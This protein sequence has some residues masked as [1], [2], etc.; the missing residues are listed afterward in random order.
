MKTKLLILL[1]LLGFAAAGFAETKPVKALSEKE[2]AAFLSKRTSGSMLGSFDS[3]CSLLYAMSDVKIHTNSKEINTTQLQTVA[4]ADFYKPTWRELFDM[5]AIQTR[6]EWKYDPAQDSWGFTKPEKPKTYYSLEM[7]K[8]WDQSDRGLYVGYHPAI[9]PV[10]MDVYIL[11]A[12]S[13][14]DPKDADALYKKL[15]EHFAMTFAEGFKKDVTPADM[16]EV[17]VNQYPA[18]HFQI[19]AP[20]GIIWRQ[21]VIVEGGKA[22]VIVSAIKPEHDAQ[23]YPDVQKMIATFKIN[24]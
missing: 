12:Y 11:G 15:R 3:F 19:T 16:K 8:G 9:A 14:D 6:S 1:A 18:L 21:W 5:I 7:A 17:T 24:P 22:F 13:A 2:Q 4:P 23:I 20:T 10:G